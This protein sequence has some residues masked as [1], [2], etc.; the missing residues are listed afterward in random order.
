MGHAPTVFDKLFLLFFLKKIIYLFLA[1][2]GLC[3]HAR[4]FS[5]CSEWGLLTAEASLAAEHGL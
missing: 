2:L 4:A 5:G 1:M 3:C